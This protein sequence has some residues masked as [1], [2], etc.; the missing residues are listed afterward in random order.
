MRAS[1]EARTDLAHDRYEHGIQLYRAGRFAAAVEEFKAAYERTRAPALLFNLGQCYRQLGDRASAVASYRA[2]A[3]ATRS[4]IFFASTSAATFTS[5][6]RAATSRPSLPDRCFGWF[7]AG[8]VRL[9]QCT[10]CIIR[11]SGRT[12]SATTRTPTALVQTNNVK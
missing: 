6:K 4:P 12:R 5:R 11:R 2:S 10:L 8:L 9:V 7:S 3:P 1:V